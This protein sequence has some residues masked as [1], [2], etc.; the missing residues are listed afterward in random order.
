MTWARS[1]ATARW[2]VTRLTTRSSTTAPASRTLKL[3]W[4]TNPLESRGSMPLLRR[5]MGRSWP[6]LTRGWCCCRLAR[7][8]R[9]R[10]SSARSLPTTRSPSPRHS[11]PARAS[12]MRMPPTRT[13]LP[14]AGAMVARLSR[15]PL[16]N[17]A[18]RARQRART[19]T[20]HQGSTRSAWRSPVAAGGVTDS[21][22]LTSHV[23][24]NV[25]VYDPSAGFV[26][27]NGWIQ[28]PPGAYKPDVSA[29]G[30]ATFSFVSKYQ[31]G[32]KV[33]TG[34]TAFQ[35]QGADLD[36][37][38]DTDDWMVGT[39]ERRAQFKGTGTLNGA[40][41]YKFLLT[42]VDG[43][44]TSAGTDRFRIKIWHYDASLQQDV[45]V[46]DN[47][48]DSSTDGTL[49]EGTAI[50]GGNIVIHTASK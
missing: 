44:A 7:H 15:V 11:R 27:G 38:S 50:G 48:L 20:R 19:S 33:P 39:G 49:S 46:Y 29:A 47:Q 21:G 10:P 17:P 12:P 6:T 22:G 36:F 37:Y 26:T 1:S 41:D 9:P 30:R 28:S 35:F 45:T 42:A 8:R 4:P 3:Y 40:G 25:V 31:K 32:A 23:S 13:A 43:K 34:T 24:R 14:G 5:P 16:S 18:A 2:R